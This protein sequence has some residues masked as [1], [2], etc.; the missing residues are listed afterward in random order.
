MVCNTSMQ[1]LYAGLLL[2]QLAD[3]ESAGKD[4]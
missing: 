2:V 4:R 1:S 3:H